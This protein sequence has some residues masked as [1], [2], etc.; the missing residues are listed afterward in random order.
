[1]KFR[2]TFTGNF[3]RVVYPLPALESYIIKSTS[4]TSIATQKPSL[5]LA[6]SVVKSLVT[7]MLTFER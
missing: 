7:D 1:M 6:F 3:L 2:L 5:S 4:R